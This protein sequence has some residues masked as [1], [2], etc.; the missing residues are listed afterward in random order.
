MT[1]IGQNILKGIEKEEGKLTRLK[2]WG[3]I[4]AASQH[5]QYGVSEDLIGEIIAHNKGMLATTEALAN[6]HKR[7]EDIA[8]DDDTSIITKMTK[9]RKIIAEKKSIL[10]AYIILI[11]NRQTLID[12][13]L[14][15]LT[16]TYTDMRAR[17]ERA[18]AT[19]ESLLNSFV[20]AT[21]KVIIPTAIRT[22]PK[23]S[24][25]AH[26]PGPI[27]KLFIPCVI[28]GGK[29]SQMMFYY[30]A[31]R[32]NIDTDIVAIQNIIANLGE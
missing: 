23:K 26:Y 24:K 10:R 4:I 9:L 27:D 16:K 11:E 17:I 19:C 18:E 1:E 15:V 5:K 20:D 29:L 3:K 13:I 12:S 21:G 32:K 31:L 8:S 28:W 22:L 2:N 14:P 6:L 7:E 30:K 25:N